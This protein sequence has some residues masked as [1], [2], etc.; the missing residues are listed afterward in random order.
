MRIFP[1]FLAASVLLFF[2]ACTQQPPVEKLK[3][4][5]A[6]ET[7]PGDEFLDTVPLKKALVI[8]AHD[9][10]DCAMAGTIAKLKDRGWQIRQ[11]SLVTHELRKG[12][13]SHPATI[14]CEGNEKLLAD[15]FYR[16]GLD[17]MQYAY[18]PIPKA[19][20]DKQF[21][22]EKI[23]DALLQK[24]NSFQ[25]SVIFTLDNEMGGYGH[26]EHIYISQLVVD[27]FRSK[28]IS[29]HRIYQSVFTDHMEREIVD[30]WLYHKMKNSG[31]PNATEMAKAMYD[32]KDGMPE[33]MVQVNIAAQAQAKMDY[34]LAYPESVRKNLRKFIPYF[35]Q[36]DAQTYF[37]VFDR[38]FFRVIEPEPVK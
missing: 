16:K 12:R 31:Y 8:V 28:A 32:L 10:D 23:M 17:T 30:R 29:A 9:D 19:E 18:V 13:H 14:I 4:F 15:G 7:F 6:T 5:A 26:P 21:L 38:E 3:K 22:R 24:I 27:L 20:M 36:F 35:E 37:S 25:P 1:L 2:S 33:P 34:L 11:V